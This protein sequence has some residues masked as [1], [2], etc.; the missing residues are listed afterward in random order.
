[1]T[2]QEIIQIMIK[3]SQ[4]NKF[5]SYNKNKLFLED[6]ALE[7]LGEKFETPLFCYS[8]SQIEHN[9]IELKKAFKRV[10]PLICYALKANFN[11]NIIKILSKLGCGID[12]V[13]NGELQ[14]S[15]KNGVD[16]QKIVFSG[17]G[18]TNKEIEIAI[19]ENIKQ[20]NVE[21]VEELD[22]I[23]IICK[24]LNKKIN[25]C[26]RV[27]PNVDAKT[28][29]KISTGRSED[30]F[31]VSDKRIFDIFKKYKTNR[32]VK[33]IG[34]SIH[35]GSQ[36]VLLEP[37]YRAFKKIKLQIL[38]LKKEGFEVSSLDLGGGVGIKYN[39]KNKILDIK[40]YAKLIDE[41]FSDLDLEII[42]EPG[43]YLVGS[44]GIILSKV[45]RT[46]SGINKD[47]VIIDAGM[48]NL[49]RPALYGAEHKIIPVHKK[50][51]T[52]LKTYE[53][54]GPIC[55]TSDVFIKKMKIHR[56]NSNDL[57]V[58]CSA[59]A[60]SSCMASNYNLREPAKEVFIKKKKIFLSNNL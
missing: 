31:G 54:V 57:V 22:E 20:I 49:I 44:S 18:K 9:F 50:N 11:S 40:S 43:R 36:I 41:L 55:E 59:G 12:V 3:V 5:L 56:L 53:I 29:E 7:N 32:F 19:K 13:S 1:M 42:I 58:I 48:D 39:D 27:N 25:V 45:I 52:N 16:N 30:K 24:R 46:K 38:K 14:Q 8:V 34:L 23:S 51:K 21:S 47:F 4:Y 10:K 35:I 26:L 60:Y 6:I 2:I 28:H 33:I 37:F 17:V 15:L